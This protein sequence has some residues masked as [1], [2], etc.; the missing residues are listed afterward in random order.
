MSILA[1]ALMVTSCKKNENAT[2]DTT[3]TSASGT[4]TSATDTSLT[5][6]TGTTDTSSTGATGGTAS[7][8]TDVE[9]EFVMKAAQGGMAEVSMGSL[10]AQQGTDAGVKAFGNR[11]VTDHGKAGDE[12]RQLATSK[13]IAFP[14]ETDADHKAKQDELSKK[15]GKD[16]DKAYIDDMVKDHE[17]DVAEFEKMAKGAKDPDLRAWVT[18]TLPT[19]QDHLKMAKDTAAKVK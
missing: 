1:A 16:F 19:L 6:A 7:T 15:T 17:H 5:T 10:A 14:A 11:M 3:E 9:K 13:G 2:N 12:L 18:K 8:L 4:N